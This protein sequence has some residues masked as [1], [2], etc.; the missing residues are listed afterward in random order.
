M[1]LAK[2]DYS[3][4]GWSFCFADNLHP[5]TDLRNPNFHLV[6]E[7]S[8]SFEDLF[9]SNLQS[10]IDAYKDIDRGSSDDNGGTPT[11]HGPDNSP[12]GG[13]GGIKI[14]ELIEGLNHEFKILDKAELRKYKEL[15]N[16]IPKGIQDLPKYAKSFL[17]KNT[18]MKFGDYTDEKPEI[19]TVYSI[20]QFHPETSVIVTEQEVHGEPSLELKIKSDQK[21]EEDNGQANMIEEEENVRK[22]RKPVNA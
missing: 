8:I 18:D 3:P 1:E 10:V 17:S 16:I 6:S 7:N 12:D 15:I 22:K 4:L 21:D 19:T 13:G 20:L 9:L 14:K 5:T 11:S 2:I